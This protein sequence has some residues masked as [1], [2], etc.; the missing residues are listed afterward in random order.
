MYNLFLSARK[1]LVHLGMRH[2]SKTLVASVPTYPNNMRRFYSDEK[3]ARGEEN[4]FSKIAN[5]LNK[6]GKDVDNGFREAGVELTKVGDEI[7]KVYETMADSLG[8][9][10]SAFNEMNNNIELQANDI[11]KHEADIAEQKKQLET[12]LE[13]YQ[14]KAEKIETELAQHVIS[15]K[16]EINSNLEVYKQ[17]TKELESEFSKNIEKQIANLQAHETKL[18]KLEER[19]N[20]QKAKFENFSHTCKIAGAFLSVG[21]IVGGY[22]LLQAQKKIPEIKAEAEKA[23]REVEVLKATAE[24]AGKEVERLIREKTEE[25][26]T[27]MAEAQ[28]AADKHMTE[29]KEAIG[30]DMSEAKKVVDNHMSEAKRIKKELDDLVELHEKFTGGIIKIEDIQKE[31]HKVQ[32]GIAQE[33]ADVIRAIREMEPSVF[34]NQLLNV[35]DGEV[36]RL[37]RKLSNSLSSRY[38][39]SFFS[40]SRGYAHQE[41]LLSLEKLRSEIMNSSYSDSKDSKFQCNDETKKRLTEAYDYWPEEEDIQFKKSFIETYL[42]ENRE[43]SQSVPR[44]G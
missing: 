32:N 6:A 42:K 44:N 40:I 41:K 3:N 31:F 16:E 7:A 10:G 19:F 26:N 14:E 21:V 37:Q 22:G 15:Q 25:L 35:I 9:L 43:D 39:T 24:E 8:E 34:K 29:T 1:P 12:S 18:E 2:L 23:S 11:Q 33:K 20:A 5:N 36:A 4:I 38:I 17:K 27:H 30:K 13:I 28:E